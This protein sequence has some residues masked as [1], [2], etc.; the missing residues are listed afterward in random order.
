MA[1]ITQGCQAYAE[2]QLILVIIP[3]LTVIPTL[4][5]FQVFLHVGFV[6]CYYALNV[7]QLLARGNI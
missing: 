7:L 2:G 6:C 3:F 1:I 5:S 4:L